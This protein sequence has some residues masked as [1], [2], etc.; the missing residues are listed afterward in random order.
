MP[1]FLLAIEQASQSED[2]DGK[3]FVQA[4]LQTYGGRAPSTFSDALTWSVVA[5]GPVALAVQPVASKAACDECREPTLKP[6]QCSKC[7]KASYCC[8]ECQVEAYREHRK[9]CVQ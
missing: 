9:V 8:R 7:K 4:M 3:H 1:L 2:G 6:M 5:G